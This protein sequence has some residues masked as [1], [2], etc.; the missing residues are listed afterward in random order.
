MNPTRF[1]AASG[2]LLLLCA[3][4]SRADFTTVSLSTIANEDL[5]LVDAA[6]P[7]GTPVTLG[8]VPFDI[9]VANPYNAW[10]ASVAANNGSGTVS[11]TG[12]AS[13]S[14]RRRSWRPPRTVSWATARR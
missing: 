11:A 9:P 14:T 1:L 5:Q 7:T 6:Y 12:S 10:M 3:S 4:S 2:A 13:T 8:G